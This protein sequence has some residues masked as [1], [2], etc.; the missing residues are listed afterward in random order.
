MG[1]DS[2]TRR[3]RGSTEIA[4]GGGGEGSF[5]RRERGE[6]KCRFLKKSSTRRVSQ[7]RFRGAIFVLTSADGFARFPTRCASN[8][9]AHPKGAPRGPRPSR[10]GSLKRKPLFR[11]NALL[12]GRHGRARKAAPD[13]KVSLCWDSQQTRNRNRSAASAATKGLDFNSSE[14]LILAQNERWQRG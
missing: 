1:G 14:S 12:L 6:R 13:S 8:G 3:R 11:A 4:R 10:P 7:K 5:S 9:S 2:T